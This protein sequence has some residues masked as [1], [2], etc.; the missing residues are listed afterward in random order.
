MP[1]IPQKGEE[2]MDI[3]EVYKLLGATLGFVSTGAAIWDRFLR[4]RPSVSITTESLPA[5]L[6][7]RVRNQAPFD[8]IIESIRSSSPCYS[9]LA[10]D[11][12]RGAV[13]EALAKDVSVLLAPGEQRLLAIVERDFAECRGDFR[14]KFTIEWTRGDHPLFRPARVTL[15]SSSSDMDRRKEAADLWSQEQRFKGVKSP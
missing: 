13:F 10:A 2:V 4:Y 1:G 3:V 5:R 15:W 8:I 9:V 11:T 14:V 12:V 7:L 6:Q